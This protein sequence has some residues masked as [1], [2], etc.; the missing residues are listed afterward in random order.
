[1]LEIKTPLIIA[2]AHLQRAVAFTN[3]VG[4]VSELQ[5]SNKKF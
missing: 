5:K 1:V 3:A 4:E 2:E